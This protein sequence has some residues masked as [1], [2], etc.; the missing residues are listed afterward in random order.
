MFCIACIYLGLELFLLSISSLI[1]SATDC[2]PFA[3]FDLGIAAIG[4]YVVAPYA[5]T[6]IE[7]SS[8]FLAAQMNLRNIHIVK[9]VQSTLDV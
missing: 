3:S 6:V 5:P 9:A 4:L 7:T 2:L 8:F 1:S